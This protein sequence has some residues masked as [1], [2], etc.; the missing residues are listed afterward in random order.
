MKSD[1]R[2]PMMTRRLLKGMAVGMCT[3]IVF[4]AIAI[5]CVNITAGFQVLICVPLLY[6]GFFVLLPVASIATQVQ[7]YLASFAV[8]SFIFIL[9]ATFLWRHCNRNTYAIWLLI[10]A[11][12]LGSGVV[13]TY[14]S[15]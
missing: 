3:A 6:P 2:P 12:L 8:N 10:M 15:I 1:A 14:L 9:L 4:T 5:W 7:F 13:I 11:L